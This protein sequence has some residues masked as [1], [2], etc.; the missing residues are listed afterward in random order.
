ML[1]INKTIL[2]A[3]IPK[4]QARTFKSKFVLR[5]G[6]SDT[7]ASNSN[8]ILGTVMDKHLTMCN[9]IKSVISRMCHSCTKMCPKHC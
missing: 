6:D 7:E 2:M 8:K 3:M 5:V 4:S 9:N 1:N